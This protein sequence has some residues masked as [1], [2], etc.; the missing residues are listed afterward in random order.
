MLEALKL[1]SVLP[2]PT[3]PRKRFDEKDLQDLA[4][5]IKEH[6]VMQPILV[7]PVPGLFSHYEI[8]AGERRWRASKL[9]KQETIP[10]IIKELDNIETMQL[11]IIENL[12]RSDLHALEEAE[13]FRQMLNATASDEH[14][15]WTAEELGQKIGKSRSYVYASL[16]LCDMS[17]F[18]KD[19]F[20]EGKFGR[21]TAL[22]IA[23][24]PGEKLQERLVKTIAESELSFRAAKDYIH[25][26]FTFDLT[27]ATWDKFDETVLVGAPSCAKCPNRSGN[28]PELHQDIESPDVCTNP[29]C[30]SSK[31]AAYADRVIKTMPRVI[32]GEEAKQIA[33]YGIDVY[34]TN[35][36]VKDIGNVMVDGKYPAK[37]LLGDDIP[38]PF[39]LID[40]KNNLGLVYHREG[41][42]ELA[43]VKLE[44]KIASGEFESA[45]NSQPRTTG[46][47]EKK[48]ARA[49]EL[50]PVY[51][52]YFKERMVQLR[53]LF[54]ADDIEIKQAIIS[55]F[56]DSTLYG[57]DRDLFFDAFN[58]AHI[59]EFTLHELII[60]AAFLNVADSFDIQP[61][62]IDE[63][64]T[65]DADYSS[66]FDDAQA[67]ELMTGVALPPL[68]AAQAQELNAES[69]DEA[70]G[71]PEGEALPETPAE[72]P[73]EAV[74]TSANED[75][76]PGALPYILPAETAVDPTPAAQ[77]SES[78]AADA[79]L[80][81]F[82]KARIKG[83]KEAA[84]RKALK[85]KKVSG[86][87]DAQ[88]GA[89]QVAS[90]TPAHYLTDEKH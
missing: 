81:G 27:K 67:L 11:Q 15:P 20:L 19:K 51:Q 26:D 37:E 13:G 78:N 40:E 4:T 89:D 22:L 3:N 58:H 35:G 30:Y 28:Y 8:V 23:R 86:Q 88:P 62:H 12:Q 42:I 48:K 65:L 71:Q 64:L 84:R 44:E 7:R 68:P 1:D 79:P 52:A 32:H 70:P 14:K 80:S 49:E 55:K 85:D 54:A 43:R 39:T 33:P 10:A 63:N 6:G 53:D 24:I 57:Q 77:A 38:E 36:Y 59:D 74:E 69:Q 45:T 73:A 90:A 17:N 87:P 31:K 2:S 82:D 29:T 25:R 16:K 56:D 83:E 72:D 18:A 76:A 46:L 75:I 66:I 9:A 60:S 21:E 41:I 34:V 47:Y 5:S 50:K 61:H